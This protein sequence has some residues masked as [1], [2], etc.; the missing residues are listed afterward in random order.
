MVIWSWL[1]LVFSIGGGL[2]FL[3]GAFMAVCLE[4]S[5]ADQWQFTPLTGAAS[6]RLFPASFSLANLGQALCGHTRRYSQ[7]VSYGRRGPFEQPADSRSKIRHCA[8]AQVSAGVE[9]AAS[10]K[11]AFVKAT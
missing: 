5:R 7:D 8:D 11:F 10:R 6:A 2:G 9:G 1:I 3:A 4:N